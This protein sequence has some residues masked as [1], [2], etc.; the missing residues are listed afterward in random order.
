MLTTL[1]GPEK[2]HQTSVIYYKVTKIQKIAEQLKSL[3]IVFESEPHKVATMSDHELWI[4][5]IRDP[6]ENLLGIME[7]VMN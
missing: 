1:Q 3:G 7:E 6:D 4:G 2:D 5:F